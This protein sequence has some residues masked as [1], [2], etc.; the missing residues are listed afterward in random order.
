MS[1][2]TITGV[3]VVRDSSNKELSARIP[4]SFDL[5]LGEGS[6]SVAPHE[7][8]A[9][10]V[11]VAQARPEI[12]V[13]FMDEAGEELLWLRVGERVALGEVVMIRP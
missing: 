4:C 8:I 12:R 6:L 1:L 10:S 3:A 9:L 11:E 13:S 7:L 5:N 2:T